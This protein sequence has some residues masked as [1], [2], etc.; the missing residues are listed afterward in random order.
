MWKKDLDLNVFKN[1]YVSFT[2]TRDS[3]C[4]HNLYFIPMNLNYNNYIKKKIIY[5]VKISFEYLFYHQNST[6][7]DNFDFC[8]EFSEE[9][10]G[11]IFAINILNIN[12]FLHIN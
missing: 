3:R 1:F 12:Q 9:K 5:T 7:C 6:V 10:D 11:N 2:K 8:F 4:K